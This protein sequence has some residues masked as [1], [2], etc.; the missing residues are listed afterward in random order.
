MLIQKGKGIKW[1]VGKIYWEIETSHYTASKILEVDFAI[2]QCLITVGPD[3][4][5]HIVSSQESPSRSSI[6][7][8]HCFLWSFLWRNFYCR[9]TN[10]YQQRVLP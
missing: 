2:H 4:L 7:R 3:K 5:L 8:W 1:V 6:D 9:E 10:C